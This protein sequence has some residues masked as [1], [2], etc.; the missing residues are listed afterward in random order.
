[1]GKTYYETAKVKQL[2]IV[3]ADEHQVIEAYATLFVEKSPKEHYILDCF[4]GGGI[5]A[6]NVDKT[7]LKDGDSVLVELYL[8]EFRFGEQ[9]NKVKGINAI[10]HRE[11]RVQ[12]EIISA[13]TVPKVPDPNYHDVIL[14]CGLYVRTNI[15]TGRKP[16]EGDYMWIEGRLDAHIIGKVG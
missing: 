8:L 14:N 7:G 3:K 1:M 16:K 4:L 9:Q 15:V 2:R 5:D 11:Y 13:S 12:G 10:Q 6:E